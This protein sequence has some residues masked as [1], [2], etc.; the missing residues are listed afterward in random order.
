MI[1]FFSPAARAERARRRELR[2]LTAELR[3]LTTQRIYLYARESWVT[4]RI[5]ELESAQ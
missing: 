4:N 2:A 5:I 1:K 3:M